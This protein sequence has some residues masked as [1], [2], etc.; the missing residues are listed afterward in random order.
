MKKKSEMIVIYSKKWRK[1]NKKKKL[2]SIL[3]ARRVKINK[4]RQ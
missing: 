3:Y 1:K 4:N 2:K